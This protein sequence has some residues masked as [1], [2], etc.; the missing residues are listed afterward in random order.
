[1]YWR[2]IC[3]LGTVVVGAFFTFQYL[4]QREVDRVTTVHVLDKAEHLVHMLVAEAHSPDQMEAVARSPAFVDMAKA[5]N[6]ATM[7]IFAPDGSPFMARVA[8]RATQ[9]EHE[10]HEH[11]ADHVHHAD[12][13]HTTA[14]AEENV[15]HGHSHS[16]QLPPEI[17]RQLEALSH[18]NDV[19][20][21]RLGS[22]EAE[23]IVSFH[24]LA[25]GDGPS[26]DFALVTVP[27]FD[28][29]NEIVA[30]VTSSL[31]T[32]HIGAAMRAGA[33]SFGLAFTLF[34]AVLFG[35]P[36]VAFWF[37]KGLAERRA[38]HVGYLSQHDALTGLLNRQTFAGQAAALLHDNRVSHIG[39]ID[40]DR[41]KT[42]NDTYGHSVGDAYLRHIGNIIV[43]TIG[44]YGLVARF[45]GDEFTFAIGRF[46]GAEAK[47]K[48]EN[49]RREITEDVEIDGFTISASI[50]IG[51]TNYRA[52]D[53]LDD[54]LQRADTALYH[55]KAAG[56]N[57]VSFYRESM[58]AAAQRRRDL[59]ELLRR[60]VAQQAFSIVYQ[61]LVD[62]KT[63]QAI[64]YEALLRL[65]NGQEDV[66]PSEFIPLAEEIGLIE[67][68]GTWVL[69]TAM[70]EMQAFDATSKVSI[71]LSA[72]QFKSGALVDVVAAALTTTGLSA[73]RVELEI[74]E[75][76]LLKQEMN[77]DSQIE[78]L[79][80]LGIRIVMDDFGTGYSSLSTLW[81]YGFDRIKID[82]SFLHALDVDSERSLQLIGSII[83][84][85]VNMGMP[86]TAE[87]IE[88]EDQ[89]QLLTQLGCDV[90]QGFHFGMPAPLGSKADGARLRAT[91]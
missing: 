14:L 38:R 62:A 25:H 64:G 86:V 56:R 53:T 50:S 42:I 15:L 27:V 24:A 34:G 73:D 17:L 16:L 67:E 68:I 48:L 26:Q 6:V 2:S 37:Q 4:V 12:D 44:S 47:H 58:G 20:R 79:K 30:F 13:H 71:N 8:E 54:G 87:G 88:T 51:V 80:G 29:S 89:R 1:M 3:V 33:G 28:A 46:S 32:A 23:A 85:G 74:T 9:D 39:Y 5:I 63:E 7:Q 69:R 59:E 66:P 72:D 36:A 81:R 77:V 75:S 83:G 18:L 21:S 19:Q 41:F 65:K 91:S 10:R 57:V 49:L 35:I 55:A 31:S 22:G 40:A 45:G 11:D 60:A 82:K 76:I 52:G 90:L 70:A 84:L 43:H 78:A 61:P